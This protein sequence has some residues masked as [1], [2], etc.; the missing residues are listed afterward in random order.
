MKLEAQIDSQ[1]A[2]TSSASANAFAIEFLEIAPLFAR[3]SFHVSEL[4]DAKN[5]T[6]LAASMRAR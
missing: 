4:S 1:K 2:Q 5:V 6:K 3:R